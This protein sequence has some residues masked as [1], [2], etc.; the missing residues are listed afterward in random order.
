MLSGGMSLATFLSF[1]FVNLWVALS[2]RD[3][4]DRSVMPLRC[5]PDV[6]MGVARDDQFTPWFG[7]LEEAILFP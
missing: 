2:I 4:S 7:G 6:A 5:L 1:F 3:D